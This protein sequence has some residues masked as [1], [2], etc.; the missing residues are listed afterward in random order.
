MIKEV[1]STSVL[2][3][4]NSNTIG[5]TTIHTHLHLNLEKIINR[6]QRRQKSR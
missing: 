1:S 4:D 5:G 2:P 3:I 6:L